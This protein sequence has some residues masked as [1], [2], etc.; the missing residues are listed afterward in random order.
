[1]D[2]SFHTI[3]MNWTEKVGMYRCGELPRRQD[4]NCRECWLWR[5]AALC[6]VTFGE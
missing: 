3:V 1:M 2:Y 6:L 5:C 4:W